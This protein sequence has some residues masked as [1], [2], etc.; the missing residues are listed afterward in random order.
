MATLS[1]RSGDADRRQFRLADGLNR[2]GRARSNEIQIEEPSISSSHC[3]LWL[4][5]ERLLVRDLGSTNGTFVNGRP[6][7]E[8]EI[9]DGDVL[10]LGTVDFAV[11]DAPGRVSI[12]RPAEAPPPP[13]F[14]PD[15]FPCCIN[16]AL[17]HAQFRCSKCGEQFCSECVR[18]LARRGGA[19]HAFCPLC[20]STCVTIAEASPAAAQTTNETGW[21]AKLTQT[22]RLRR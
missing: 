1:V 2:I 18:L 14:A 16:H 10:T 12:P 15:G 20:N 21:L 8:S 4:M 3:E 17:A 6:I 5:K 9:S 19:Q 11:H 7:T 13:R 22:L